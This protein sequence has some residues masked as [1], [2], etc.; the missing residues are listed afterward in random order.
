MSQRRKA[1]AF[2]PVKLAT[3]PGFLLTVEQ[4]DLL[5]ALLLCR[6]AEGLSE[7]S[8]ERAIVDVLLQTRDV[9]EQVLLGPYHRQGSRT[10]EER[11]EARR[12]PPRGGWSESDRD[13]SCGQGEEGEEVGCL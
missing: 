1:S 4:S 10:A 8:R 2:L 9:G 5:W 13:A 11:T 6:A 12:R 3:T 7:P